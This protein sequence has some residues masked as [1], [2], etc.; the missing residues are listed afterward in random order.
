[1]NAMK[2]HDIA[3]KLNEQGLSTRSSNILA[4][5]G[6]TSKEEA[7]LAIQ[8][9]QLSPG[10]HLN[11]G[12]VSFR[13]VSK[14]C[15]HINDELLVQTLQN[16]IRELVVVGD[17]LKDCRSAPRI[18]AWNETSKRAKQVGCQVMK[19]VDEYKRLKKDHKDLR[20]SLEYIKGPLQE[21]DRTFNRC[22]E[23]S[24]Q[25]LADILDTN[26]QRIRRV[27]WYPVPNN[28][29]PEGTGPW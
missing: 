3:D 1:M 25:D 22:Q 14:W 15:G 2:E 17:D 9:G 12:K 27:I 20:E 8:T 7:Y 24:R 19:V 13:E 4:K 21:I 5:M 18:K 28:K 23:Y 16:I 29:R 10:S 6:I 11:F 26:L